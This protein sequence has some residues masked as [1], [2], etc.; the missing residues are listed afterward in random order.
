MKKIAFLFL[1]YDEINNERLWRNFFRKAK[2][3][4]YAIYIHWKYDKKLE[5]LD[6]FRIKNPI[7]TAYAE[8]SLV[9]AQNLLLREA[10]K[11]H[12]IERFVF[13]S[14]S[15]IPLKPF[16][17][18]YKSLFS[19]EHCLFNAARAE[20][21]FERGRGQNLAKS[22]GQSNV[23]KA[24]QWSVLTRP[25]AQ[26]L[27]TS[28]N[29]LETCFQPGIKDLADEYFYLSY[30]YYLNKQDHLHLAHYSAIEC[31]TFEFWNDKK[32][33]FRDSFT[34][35]HPENWDRRLKTY[36]DITESELTYLLNAPC[37]FGRKFN[38]N[39]V[40]KGEGLIEAV[41][42]EFYNL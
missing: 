24:S 28:D 33:E 25:I 18:I 17:Y 6:K 27:S 38:K 11:D 2:S 7:P 21:V 34:S 15:C 12:R 40:V 42:S 19:N 1:I 14:N 4:A 13:I 16:D 32:Y 8:F 31:V 10:L 23:R 35:D 36:F 5:Y 41:I 20:H 30:L 22:F 9:K 26:I 39:C 29:V 37:Y 3:E